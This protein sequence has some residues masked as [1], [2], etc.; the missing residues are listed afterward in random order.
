MYA[1]D[2][3]LLTKSQMGLQQKFDCL[4]KFCKDWCLSQC[5]KKQTLILIN[6][7][8]C[9]ISREFLLDTEPIEYV[10]PIITKTFISE[11]LDVSLWPRRKISKSSKR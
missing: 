11:H 6:K 3:V 10:T 7:A 9:H 8:G 2:V 4:S 5:V 1:D